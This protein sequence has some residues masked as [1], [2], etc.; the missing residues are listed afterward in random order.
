MTYLFGVANHSPEML[1]AEIHKAGLIRDR[2]EIHVVPTGTY[3][4]RCS[5]RVIYFLS[6][7]DVARNASRL[8]LRKYDDTHVFVFDAA[9][10]LCS[11]EVTPVDYESDPECPKFGFK[12]KALSRSKIKSVKAKCQ[13]VYRKFDI[14]P[15]LVSFVRTGSL[16]N[17]L[18][19]FIYSLPTPIQTKVKVAVVSWIYF[20]KSAKSLEKLFN[21]IQGIQLSDRVKEKARDIL[22]SE[23][24]QKYQNF[25]VAYRDDTSVMQRLRDFNV[26]P[27]EV[28]YILSIVNSDNNFADSYDKA[29]N[30]KK[31]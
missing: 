20:S 17:P 18:M 11:L 4:E 22:L 6:A 14:L 24:A 1:T 31:S 27:Y 21:S 28:N 8:L 5:K 12:H 9:I 23:V 10:S 2:K 19:T 16:L 29:K 30:R 25:F 26:S 3:L 7:R 13:H 15:H